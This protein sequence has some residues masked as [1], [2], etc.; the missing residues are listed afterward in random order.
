MDKKERQAALFPELEE[1]ISKKTEELKRGVKWP[2]GGAAAAETRPAPGR[3]F[4]N[5]A[6]AADQRRGDVQRHPAAR[7]R[8]DQRHVAAGGPRRRDRRVVPP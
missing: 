1:L 8:R 2:E 3:S 4:G 6:A 7:P 5:G